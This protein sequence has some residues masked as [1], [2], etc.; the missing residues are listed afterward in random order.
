MANTTI[1]GSF[2]I[3]GTPLK[4]EESTEAIGAARMAFHKT[5][6]GELNGTSVVEML[7]MMFKESASGAYV[8]LERVTGRLQGR[9]GSFAL[10]HSSIMDNGR[11]E[12]RITVVP[13]SGTEQL[14]GLSGAMVIDIVEKQHYYTF[15]FEIKK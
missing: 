5:F 9:K 10:Q 6:H 2:D 8:A 7:G 14:Q 3:K 12:Q 15:E 1:K 11:P 13:G 4:T